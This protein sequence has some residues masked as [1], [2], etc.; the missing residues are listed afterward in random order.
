MNRKWL[1][2]LAA[3]VLSVALLGA[4]ALAKR[5]GGGGSFGSRSG[6]SR[7]YTPPPS[8][9]SSPSAPSQLNQQR[10][11]PTPPVA[12]PAPGMGSRF[13][14]GIGGFL[15]GG[16]LG[17][18]LFGGGFGGGFGGIGLMD[19]LLIGGIIF[20][21]F[22]L[23][24]RK[25]QPQNQ[26]QQPGQYSQ[27]DAHT[28]AE[29]SWDNLRS[30][31]PAGAGGGAGAFGNGSLAAQGQSDAPQGPAVPE[32]FNVPEFLEGAKTVYTRL[33][34]SWDRRDLADIALFTTREVHE[35]MTRQAQADPGPSRTEL[36]MVNARL[37]EYREEGPDS[38]ATVL[39]DV[40]MREDANEDR[41][42]QVREV[43]HFVRETR[44]AASNWR[45]EGIQQLEG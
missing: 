45:L 36:L 28:R 35:E 1:S 14:W 10:P 2:I 34:S 38:I 42:K 33:Q 18:M 24:R 41:P 23:L 27:P 17:S 43:W 39:F 20:L 37:V 9:P 26:G 5:A 22:K 16:L 30:T 31:P 6:Y 21:A 25:A 32:G 12:Q 4:D 15:M 3:L 8:A 11:A 13:G 29:Q 40:L 19:I 44:N 7:S